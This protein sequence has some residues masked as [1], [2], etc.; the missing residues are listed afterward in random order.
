MG[1]GG[2]FGVVCVVLVVGC[3]VLCKV[4]VLC[5]LFVVFGCV[6]VGVVVVFLI[7]VWG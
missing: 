6:L 4:D 3:V 1:F 5:V 7:V 2:C